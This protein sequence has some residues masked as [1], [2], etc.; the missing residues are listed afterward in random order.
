MSIRCVNVKEL[1]LVFLGLVK[2]LSRSST[3]SRKSKNVH[4]IVA[5]LVKVAART[6]LLDMVGPMIRMKG[7]VTGIVDQRQVLSRMRRL[8]RC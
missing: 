2:S 4:S 7:G 5:R 8:R 3:S 1:Q 6:K